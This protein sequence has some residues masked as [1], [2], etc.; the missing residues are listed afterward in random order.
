MYIEAAS[1]G[2]DS[3]I[4]LQRG[5]SSWC[6]GPLSVAVTVKPRLAIDRLDLNQQKVHSENRKKFLSEGLFR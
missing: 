5:W 2:S 1:A 3:D 4:R 6:T